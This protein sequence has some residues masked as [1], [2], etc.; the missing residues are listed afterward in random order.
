M[1]MLGRR[2]IVVSPVAFAFVFVVVFM[3]IAVGVGVGVTEAIV[4]AGRVAET[5][6]TV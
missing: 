6:T 2:E 5:E 3:V 4:P 1:S